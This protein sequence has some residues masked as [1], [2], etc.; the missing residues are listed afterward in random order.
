MGFSAHCGRLS[1]GA[2]SAR[3]ERTALT[4]NLLRG[5]AAGRSGEAAAMSIKVLIADDHRLILKAVR[6]ALEPIQRSAP[7]TRVVLLSAFSDPERADEAIAHGADGYISKAI[8]PLEL[9]E[10]IR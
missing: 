5:P 4:G 6:R 1:D 7:G 2:R 9:P 3:E 8:D 10:A